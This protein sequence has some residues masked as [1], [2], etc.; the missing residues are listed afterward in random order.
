MTFEALLHYGKEIRILESMAEFLGWDQETYMPPK[1]C[2]IRADQ[3]SLLSRLSHE[4]LVDPKFEEALVTFLEKHTIATEKDQK[5]LDCARLWLRDVRKAKKLPSLF[6]EEF[7][8]TCAQAQGLWEKAKYESNFQI[9]LPVFENIVSLVRQKA[10]YLGYDK[11]P[12]DALLDEYEPDTSTE[13]VSNLFSKIRPEVRK[14][15]ALSAQSSGKR[16]HAPRITGLKTTLE[17]EIELSREIISLIGYDWEKSRLDLSAHPFS[18]SCHPNDSRITIRRQAP[19]MLD[20][21]MSALH[22]A[23]HSLYEMG[24]PVNY[25]GS[26]ICQAASLGVHESQSRLWEVMIGR[27]HVFSGHISELIY[28]KTR[29]KISPEEIFTA[30]NS[31]NPS[32]IRTEADEVTYP[33]HVILRFEIEQELVSGKLDPKDLPARWN[34]GMKDS[35]GICPKNDREGCLQDIHWSMGA[36]GYFPTYLLGTLYASELFSKMQEE[37]PDLAKQ[38]H[39]KNFSAIQKWLQEKIWSHGRRYGSKELI[40]RA[41]NRPIEVENYTNYLKKKFTSPTL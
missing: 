17:Q 14:L 11:N 2:D 16:S 24:L 29:H 20:Q 26:P 22:E 33:L 28:T 10:E 34:E 32:L 12:Y 35:L 31:V 8:R 15:V 40:E 30:L 41:L 21:I 13:A 18:S 37:I 23:G 7:S 19:D 39:E 25:Y 36:F 38:L 6:V 1:A 27:S 3:R 4:K 9:F 5:E